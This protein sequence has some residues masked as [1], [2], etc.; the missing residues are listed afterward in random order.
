VIRLKINYRQG[1]F[2]IYFGESASR[3]LA[4]G[5]DSFSEKIEKLTNTE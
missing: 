1:A 4:L 3:G 2:E 5:S